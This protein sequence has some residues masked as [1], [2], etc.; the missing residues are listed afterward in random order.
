MRVRQRLDRIEAVKLDLWICKMRDR[1]AQVRDSS[2]RCGEV[3]GN[4]ATL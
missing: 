1:R 4:H 3:D 2:R